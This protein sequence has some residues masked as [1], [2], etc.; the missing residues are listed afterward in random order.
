MIIPEVILY[1]TL[2]G[3]LAVI[4]E[5]YSQAA[6]KTK[7]ILHSLLDRDDNDDQLSIESY[8]YLKQGVHIFTQ[9]PASQRQIKAFI[10][11]NPA[12]A[13]LPSLHILL[14]SESDMPS[15][16]SHEYDTYEQAENGSFGITNYDDATDTL[17]KSITYNN[18]A[19]YNVMITSDNSSE[20]VLIYHVLKACFSMFEGELGVR[21]LMNI[22]IGGGDISMQS[23]LVPA[24]I[25]HR[26]MSISFEYANEIKKPYSKQ[27]INKLRVLVD[28]YLQNPV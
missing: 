18:T 20:V 2:N 3:I 7:T 6:N 11:Y 8:N 10:G 28:K 17:T 27:A 9:T 12:V 5:D 16:I 24:N 26:N 15:G 21:G 14:P 1:N 23:D 4:R 22:R 19:T 25:F 13:G